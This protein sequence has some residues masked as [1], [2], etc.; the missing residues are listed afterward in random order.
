MIGWFQLIHAKYK[1]QINDETA[2]L[3]KI[4]LAIDTPSSI[5]YFWTIG[6]RKKLKCD[7]QIDKGT[8]FYGEI[9]SF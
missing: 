3:N 2:E 4:I 9:Y 7:I 5:K 6:H 1:L 8:I